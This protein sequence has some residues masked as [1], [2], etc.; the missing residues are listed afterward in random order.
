VPVLVVSTS[1]DNAEAINSV[2]RNR[3]IPAHCTRIPGAMDFHDEAR[4]D[5]LL[6]IVFSD[7]HEDL[8]TEVLRVRDLTDTGLPVVSCR[9]T[10]DAEQ[11]SADVVAGAADLVVL[12][13]RQRLYKVLEREIR[14]A[15]MGQALREAIAVAA[16]YREQLKTF[17][18]GSTDAIAH[19]Q[20][21]IIIDTNPAWGQLF[22]YDD[23]A[24]MVG[25]PIM[26]LFAADSR[27][28]LKGALVACMQDRWPGDKLR[29]KGM[30]RNGDD[31]EL[32][33]ELEPSEFEQEPCVRINIASGARDDAA[34]LRDLREA[35]C[36]DPLTGFFSRQHFVEQLQ[37]RFDTPLSGGMRALAIIRPDAFGRLVETV[38]PIASE[39]LLARMAR[40]LRDQVQPKDLYGRFGGTAFA[41][42]LGRGNN[43][44]LRAWGE[45]LCRKLAAQ[46]FE[47]EGKS[48][49]MTCTVGLAIADPDRKSVD[50]LI[51]QAVE[52]CGVGRA[53]GGN[54]V[55]QSNA[56]DASTRIEESDRLWVPRIKQALI[57]NRFRLARQPVASL[58]GADVGL[59]DVLVRMVDE[60]GDEVL[61]S[62]FMAAAE[63]NQ[64]VKNIDRWVIGATLAWLADTEGERA[65]VRLSRP[66]ITDEMLLQWLADR[67]REAR[68]EPGRMIF[69]VAETAAEAQLKATRDLAKQLRLA[70][71]GFAIEH[72]GVGAR[73]TQI[74]S[75]VPMD[76]LK[77]DGSFMQGLAG[78]TQLQ[79]QVSDLV[80]E[81]K[82][83]D[84]LTIAE[85]VED[86][87]TM[88]V[89]WQIGVEY[90]Q[91][92]Q[93][94][95]P[96]VVLSEEPQA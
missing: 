81:A 37:A 5:Y 65:F 62:E 11:L 92:Y 61:P 35:V 52:A 16:S 36:K 58:T 39:T 44:D 30:D 76:Y 49:A 25:L 6:A 87:N 42:L 17:M 29:C 31:L 34:L 2:L 51:G 47:I 93:V 56:D 63:R 20:E 45:G 3:G 46:L 12:S 43:R 28:T 33:L 95:E 55:H 24:E 9:K 86:A 22:G 80:S 79:N 77:V 50:Q 78:D 91:G 10:M 21:G 48:I 57:E 83:R 7:E 85:R 82:Q 74:I 15:R 68:V 4:S 66:S 38:G 84:I 70:G 71:F 67:L 14:R 18:A 75:H 27:A 54:R 23:E 59:V 40:V 32:E 69:Q 72:F 64:L 60:Q 73:P 94:M 88:A 53:Q 90:I 41:V 8:L 13:Q 1:P 26:D 89:L 19:V 96:E